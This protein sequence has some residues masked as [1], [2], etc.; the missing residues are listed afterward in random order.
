MVDIQIRGA[1][2][3]A[4]SYG[5]G[6]FGFSYSVSGGANGVQ[7]QLQVSERLK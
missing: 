2:G 7:V 4:G 5:I 6:A 3:I 1:G